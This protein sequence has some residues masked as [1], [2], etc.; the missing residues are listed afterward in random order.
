MDLLLLSVL[1]GFSLGIVSGLIPGIHTNNFALLLVA[2]SPFF[3]SYGFT[4]LHIAIIILSNAIAHTFLDIIPSVF[5]GAPDADTSLAVLP[6]HR[7]LMEGRGIEAIR[8][9]ALGS[10]SAIILS[11]VLLF[12]MKITFEHGYKTIS[13]NMGIILASIAAI[14]ILTERGEVVEGQGSLASLKFKG[15]ASILFLLSGWLGILSFERQQM[16]RGFLNFESSVL[17][18]LFTGL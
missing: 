3:I 14:M 9:S 6:G 12:P 5:L 7:L 4:P 1:I 10:A 15:Y 11:L 17:F 16:I 18:P 13:D 8:L 2:S